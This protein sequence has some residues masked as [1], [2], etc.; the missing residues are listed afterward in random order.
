M[1]V[2]LTFNVQP[3]ND[4]LEFAVSG[5]SNITYN[6][7]ISNAFY[8]TLDEDASFNIS[9]NDL[10]N[11]K[12][13]VLLESPCTRTRPRLNEYM[14]D[15]RSQKTRIKRNITSNVVA[16]NERLS[17]NMYFLCK[18]MHVFYSFQRASND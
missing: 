18:N 1:I 10:Y 13:E 14:T 12:R 7:D 16:R 4:V 6:T 5:N 2:I 3:V 9:L 17:L 11:D 8:V 15:V